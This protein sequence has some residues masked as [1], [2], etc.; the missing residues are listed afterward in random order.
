MAHTRSALKAQ[1]RAE[2]RA[3]RNRPIRSAIRTQVKK[4]SAA[5]AVAEERAGD[6]VR[7][8]VSALDRAAGKGVIHRNS[9][10]RRKSRLMARLHAL[11]LAR[12]AE[13]QP[14]EAK[15]AAKA[16]ATGRTAAR[17]KAA[18]GLA[19]KPTTRRSTRA[20]TG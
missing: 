14:A 19:K 2:Q 11:T 17:A 5:I 16:G 6:V 9:A 13:A 3:A 20:K 8:A 15:P 1:R 10:A 7:Q 4:A 18:N 12:R